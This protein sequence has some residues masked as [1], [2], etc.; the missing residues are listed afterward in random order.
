MLEARVSILLLWAEGEC[1][2][3]P[4]WG[5]RPSAYGRREARIVNVCV[6]AGEAQVCCEDVCFGR[7]VLAGRAW[8]GMRA[9]VGMGAKGVCLGGLWGC[10]STR[11]REVRRLKLWLGQTL[12]VG[13]VERGERGSVSLTR[14]LSF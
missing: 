2:E 3:A 6:C 12:S 4:V 9:W 7:H 10:E 14:R 1:C 11:V 13:E 8:F 5:L